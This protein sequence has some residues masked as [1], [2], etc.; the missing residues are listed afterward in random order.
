M[1]IPPSSVAPRVNV[2]ACRR[3]GS[4]YPLLIQV[5]Q[6][7]ITNQDNQAEYS[8]ISKSD[9]VFCNN[10]IIPEFSFD[11]Y[12]RI[13]KNILLLFSN[14]LNGDEFTS[15]YVLLSI[16]SRIHTR[17]DSTVLGYL[18]INI[19]GLIA[20]DS[21]MLALQ[22]VIKSIVPRC[23]D[24]NADINGLN[25]N[26]LLPIRDYEKNIVTSSPLQL[27][28]GTVLLINETR[29]TEGA[30]TVQGTKSAHSLHTLCSSQNLPIS[31]S[32]CEIKIPTDLSFIFFSRDSTSSLFSGSD[33]IRIVTINDNKAPSDIDIEE[34]SNGNSNG[35]SNN[36]KL[37][38]ED[39]ELEIISDD[40]N[41]NENND[42]EDYNN[43]MTNDDNISSTIPSLSIEEY[44]EIRLWWS[45]V[46][47]FDAVMDPSMI[48][49]AEDD[50][51]LSR[52]ENNDL[53]PKS[54][55]TWLTVSRLMA[56]SYGSRTIEPFHWKRM[57]YFEMIRLNLLK[58]E[59]KE[60]K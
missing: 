21:R 32:Y 46:R 15:E 27:G 50:F 11:D 30:L 5:N 36:D 18:P 44:E 57:K 52:Q 8:I 53:S 28:A 41:N 45:F 3:L 60:I 47:Q 56:F 7:S 1:L 19:A 26:S 23:L 6:L 29:L 55:H 14:A 35:I 43:I 34:H 54:F 48:K 51:V 31:F 2:L 13:R 58:N 24:I 25:N 12:I 59:K 38:D 10:I 49:L 4:S 20:D 22:E 16:L 9:G 17:Q 40:D 33:V 42:N 39:M 37:D